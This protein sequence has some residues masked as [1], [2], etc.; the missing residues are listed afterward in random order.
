MKVDRWTH[1][2]LLWLTVGLAMR[3]DTGI[4]DG[5]WL[6][7]TRYKYRTLNDQQLAAAW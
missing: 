7:W 3:F 4:K 2:C 1:F 5:L 6:G